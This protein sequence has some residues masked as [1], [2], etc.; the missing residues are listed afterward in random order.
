MIMTVEQARK[1][2]HGTPVFVVRRYPNLPTAIVATTFRRVIP[3][4][5]G[6]YGV[7]CEIGS[8]AW[9]RSARLHLT[10]DA[11]RADVCNL[12][13]ADINRLQSEMDRFS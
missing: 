4:E 13:R 5:P 6:A 2:D 1:L 11:A 8:L 10:E 7:E 9:V 12:I 3:G